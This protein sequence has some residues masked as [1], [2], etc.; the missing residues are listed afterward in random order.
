MEVRNCKRCGKMFTY[1]GMAVCNDC[2]DQEEQDFEDVKEYLEKHPGASTLEVSMQTEVEVR[3]ITRFLRE[4]RLEA[5]G[6]Q[7]VD[8]DLTCDKCGKAISAGRYCDDCLKK[9][10]SELKEAAAKLEK[11]KTRERNP[12][13]WGSIH[14]RDRNEEK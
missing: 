4:G 10:Q 1:R 11:D 7:I 3:T 2:F 13:H 5:D 12:V 14:T 6:V 8:S 9:L